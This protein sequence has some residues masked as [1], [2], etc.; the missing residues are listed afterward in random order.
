MIQY[1][2][3]S[4]GASVGSFGARGAEVTEASMIKSPRVMLEVERICITCK[5]RRS[6]EKE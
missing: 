3:K 6:H 2:P 4:G 1:C 5:N